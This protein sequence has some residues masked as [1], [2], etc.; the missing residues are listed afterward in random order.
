VVVFIIILPVGT[1]LGWWFSRNITRPI[2]KLSDTTTKISRDADYSVRVEKETNDEIGVLYDSFNN[3]LENISQKNQEIHKLNESLEERVR[4]RT[5]DLLSA[6]E[7]AEQADRTKSTFLA[8]MSHEIRTPMNSILGYSRL[9]NK[10]IT[11]PKQKEYL[12]IVETSGRNLLALIEDI[13]D[14]SKIEAGKIELDFKA[15]DTH[16]LIE[17]I[18]NIFRIKTREKG[19]DF[20]IEEDPAIPQGLI[21]DETRIRQILFNL[22]GNAVKFTEEGHIKLTLTRTHPEKEISKVHLIFIVEDTGI[23]IAEDQIER[24]FHAFEQQ[25]GQSSRYGGTGLGLAI[26]KRLVEIMNG[27]ISVSSQ[28]GQG[29]L[30]TFELPEVE[31]S[32]L[33]VTKTVSPLIQHESLDFQGACVLVVEDNPHNLALIRSFL[34]AQNIKVEEA[35]NAH[36]AVNALKSGNIHPGLILMDMK[37]PVMDGFEAT[38]LLKSDE[39]LSR[40]P[41]IALTA[42]NLKDEKEKLKNT[43]CD[44]FLIKPIDEDRLFEEL[45][46]HL[47]FHHKEPVKREL[48]GM[49]SGFENYSFDLTGIQPSDVFE[50]HAVLSTQLQDRWAQLGDS[51][52]LDRWTEFAAEIRN[53][54]KKFNI[55][56][57]LEYAGYMAENIDNL[58]IKELKKTIQW[59]PSLVENIKRML[60]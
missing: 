56:P 10:Q 29:S 2:L 40:I 4:Q 6:K 36:E 39:R 27:T 38:R 55:S 37:T 52:I 11:D 25:K 20:I 15:V 8:N 22:V 51:L 53:L 47:P 48:T 13:L 5:L 19:I 17:E 41:I 30:F 50:I 44:G 43:P 59:F 42:F 7:H 24:I 32:P 26:T 9:L 33:Q 16:A 35:E 46:K 54:G 3:M 28:V 31:I 12:D 23:G 49:S 57:L 34:E 60:V 58:N 18:G 14:L 1:L 21:L 45:K